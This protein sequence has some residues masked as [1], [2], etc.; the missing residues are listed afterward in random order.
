MFGS[1]SAIR[2]NAQ[3]MSSSFFP[4][5]GLWKVIQLRMYNILQQK[6]FYNLF[7]PLCFKLDMEPYML[8]TR[9]IKMKKKSYV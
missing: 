1:Y 5:N 6:L 8:I 7:F 4:P 3:D 2:Q 9:H